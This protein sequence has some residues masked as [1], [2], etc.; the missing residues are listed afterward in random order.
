MRNIQNGEGEP[1]KTLRDEAALAVLPVFLS[2]AIGS[3]KF[4]NVLSAQDCVDK[5]IAAS[6]K[7]ADNYMAARQKGGAV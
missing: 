2:S 3:Y 7:L 5:A 4:E 1:V 6:L